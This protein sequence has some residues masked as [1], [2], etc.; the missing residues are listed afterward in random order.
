[1]KSWALRSTGLY[2]AAVGKDFNLVCVLT[3]ERDVSTDKSDLFG[4]VIGVHGMAVASEGKSD[5]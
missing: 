4:S 1:M 5:L 3:D 2:L